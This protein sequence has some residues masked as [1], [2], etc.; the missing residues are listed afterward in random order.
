MYYDPTELKGVY[1]NDVYGND[2][3]G[4]DVYGNAFLS[5]QHCERL[6]DLSSSVAAVQLSW[7][8][9]RVISPSRPQV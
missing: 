5:G 1:G 7:M 3:Y 9:R 4:N 8:R 2:V 6:P